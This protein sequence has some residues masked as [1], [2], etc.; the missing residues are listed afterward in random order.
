MF[1]VVWPNFTKVLF[2]TIFV[3]ELII[4]LM[5]NFEYL[6]KLMNVR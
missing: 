4:K 1:L 5:Q 2:E 6:S 3:T